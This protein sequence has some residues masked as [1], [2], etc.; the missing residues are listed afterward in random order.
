MAKMSE[1]SRAVWNY[2]VNAGDAKIT[3]DDIAEGTGLNKKTVNGCVVAFQRKEYMKRTEAVIATE[4]GGSKSVK[5]ISL[6][7]AGQAFDPDAEPVADAQ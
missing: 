1:N 5:F 7:E 4:D 3:L 2:V 6:T